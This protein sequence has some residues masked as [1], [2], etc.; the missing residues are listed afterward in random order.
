ML[1][2]I[3][4]VAAAQ[5]GQQVEVTPLPRGRN[6]V[7]L[8]LRSRVKQELPAAVGL[9]DHGQQLEQGTL[10]SAALADEGEFGAGH[11]IERRYLETKFGPARLVAL[12]DVAQGEDLLTQGSASSSSG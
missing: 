3:T 4:D 7:R 5:V 2:H 12:H 10:A 6:V 8:A 9:Q 11:N 1:Q